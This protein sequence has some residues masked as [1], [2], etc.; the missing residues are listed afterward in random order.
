M[1]HISESIIGKRGAGK[2][3]GAVWDMLSPMVDPRVVTTHD[4][5]HL[6][7]IF[8]VPFDV[9]KTHT[10]ILSILKDVITLDYSKAYI[11]PT[12]ACDEKDYLYVLDGVNVTLNVIRDGRIAGSWTE[13]ISGLENRSEVS[14]KL[15]KISR[16]LLDFNIEGMEN[17]VFRYH[18]DNKKQPMM[19]EMINIDIAI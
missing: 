10:N 3:S 7:Y 4:L 5:N 13:Y 16:K 18:F 17:I 15:R 12:T 11:W 9:K 1:R 19:L 8:T 14:D 2:E 6:V